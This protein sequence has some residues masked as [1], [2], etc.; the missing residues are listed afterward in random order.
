MMKMDGLDTHLTLY[1]SSMLLTCVMSCIDANADAEV[2]RSEQYLWST[3]RYGAPR[4]WPDGEV[5]TC[6]SPG[7][8]FVDTSPDY[9]DHV[10][11]AAAAL[12]Q[13]NDIPD[14][15]VNFTGL[16]QCQSEAP[17]AGGYRVIIHNILG[18]G[19]QSPQG[20]LGET[21]E[22]ATNINLYALGADW[23][24]A[25]LHEAAHAL[26]FDH[27]LR[28]HEGMTVYVDPASGCESGVNGVDGD[29]DVPWPG[30]RFTAYDPASIMNGT[31]CHWSGELS[32]LDKLGL[33]IVYPASFAQGIGIEAGHAM[34]TP[35][36]FVVRR[37]D[38]GYLTSEWLAR[39]ASHEAFARAASG[40]KSTWTAWSQQTDAFSSE[41]GDLTYPLADL[42]RGRN[43]IV[44]NFNDFR[45]REHRMIETAVVVDDSLHTAILMA[46][47]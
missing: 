19:G 31:Y 5:P 15:A 7:T 14:S 40:Y 29:P 20:Y 45:E 9:T 38:D 42:E 30:M 27:E 18:G 16:G 24:T 6:F 25:I 4:Y 47:L 46:A 22:V 37:D 34:R 41:T 17:V 28:R 44:G 10:A 1:L 35:S 36:G 39:G 3:T 21:S 43:L 11:A 32:R 23:N 13:Y 26:G 33:E 2:G 12:R 8:G